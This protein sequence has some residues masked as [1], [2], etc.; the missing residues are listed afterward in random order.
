[1]TDTKARLFSLVSDADPDMHNVGV[2]AH[3]LNRLTEDEGPIGEQDYEAIGWLAGE[4]TRIGRR[5]DKALDGLYA[6]A[7]KVQP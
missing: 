3:A 5:L 6:F 4:L 1:M 2:I 7:K